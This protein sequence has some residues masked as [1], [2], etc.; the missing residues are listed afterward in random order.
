MFTNRLLK[1]NDV[2]ISAIIIFCFLFTLG[3]SSDESTLNSVKLQSLVLSA[4]KGDQNANQ[5]LSGLIDAKHFGRIDFNQFS[6]D[7]SYMNRKYYYSLLL[8]YPEPAL[9]LFA[10]YDDSQRFYLLDKSLNGNITVEWAQQETKNF[11]FVQERFLTKDVLSIDRLSI[12]LVEDTTAGLI[13]RELSRLVKDKD[14]ISHS[15]INI[16]DDKIIT[17][18]TSSTF[19]NISNR[20]DTFYFNQLSNE[21]LSRT[22]I[23]KDFVKGEV[24]DFRWI[25]IK[26]QLVSNIFNKGIIIS[27]EGYQI[28]LDETWKK[29]SDHQQIKYLS[30]RLIGESYSHLALR[31]NFSV[32]K[33]PTN[34]KAEDFCNYKFGKSTVGKY[35]MRSTELR[36]TGNDVFQIFEHFCGKERFL[37]IFESKSSSYNSNKKLFDD[38]INSFFIECS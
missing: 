35:K 1:I 14:T 9:N 23:F 27:G 2:K 19:V 20:T 34:K 4:L 3:C 15:V 24:R 22:E 33:I 17:K 6:I 31:A 11:C 38:I 13:F 18:I 7:S 8:E 32:L 16:S 37:L 28:S 29:N 25:P 21:Y 30:G 10:I 36:T 5:Q 12:Y 26:P